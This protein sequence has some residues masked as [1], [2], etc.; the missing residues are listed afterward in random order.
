[1]P[2]LDFTNRD[3]QTLSG[4]LEIPDGITKAYAVFA[5]CFTCS[6]NVRAATTVS[7]SLAEQG[8]AV[9]RF[10]FTG[11][12]NSEGDF[13]N[14]S[15]SSNVNDL[16]DAATALRERHDAPQLLIGHSLGGAAVLLAA[17]QL[18][19]VKAVATIGAPS[20]PAHVEKLIGRSTTKQHDDGSASIELGGRELR[21]SSSFISDLK[22]NRIAAVLPAL[23]KPIMIFH[24]PVDTVVSIDHA[25]RL[26]EVAQHPKSFVSLDGADHMLSN[27]DDGRFVALTL[28][29]W[30]SR[31]VSDSFDV[32]S[33]HPH[34]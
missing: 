20:E 7:K 2:L 6:K 29:A 24:S 26:Y 3:G 19:S 32:S 5:H 27:P 4:R 34:S 22:S 11:L 25:R 17:A 8:V 15:F 10:D 31:Y 13:A 12:G 9:L 23:H 16:I 21:I 30:A 33:D 18:D 14:S 1:M 28:A